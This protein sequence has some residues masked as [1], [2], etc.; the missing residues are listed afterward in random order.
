MAKATNALTQGI[1]GKVAGLVFRRNR[2][3][4]IAIGNAP[5]TS[6]K[7]LSAAQQQT[8]DKFT[9]GANFAREVTKDPA[10]KAE[11]EARI[12]ENT[13]SAYS[14]AIQDA[15]Q[16]PVIHDVDF[17]AYTGQVGDKIRIIATD[18]HAVRRVH[19]RILNPDASLVE[20]GDAV[21][22]GSG[23]EWLYIATAANASLPGDEI[24]VS[25]YDRPGNQ[26]LTKETI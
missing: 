24:H 9:Q 7:P 1:S 11:Y 23:V 22:Q 21:Q 2:D 14:A 3:G 18:N 6:T 19:V 12:D 25:A 20:E 26:A 15:L 4:S 10:L 13:P 17:S 16:G 5:R 8:R